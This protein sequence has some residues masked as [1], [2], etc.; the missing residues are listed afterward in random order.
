MSRL[1]DR[2]IKYVS[3]D[4]QSQEFTGTIPSTEKQLVLS[5][6]LKEE[7]EELGLSDV[8]MTEHGYVYATIP[9]NTDH[10]CPVVGFL[11]HMDTSPD[12]SGA[13]VKPQ[14]VYNYDG[15]IITLN[16]ELG[17]VT[18]PA[19]FPDLKKYIGKDLITSDG[20]TL[21]GGDDKAGIAEIMAMVDLLTK[22]NDIKHG[23]VKIAFTPDEEI[24]HGPDFFDIEGWGAD[25]AYTVDG[26]SF[27][28]IEY[29][30]FNA[31]DLYVTVHGRNIHPGDAKGRMKNSI[32]IAM[33]YE[34]LLPAAQK[35]EYTEKYEG[36]Y[37][38]NEI[39]GN[40]EN[41]K[42]HYLIRDHDREKFEEKKDLARK[43]GEFLNLKY[44]A[45]TVDVDITDTYYNMAE[46]I[47][48]NM[49][50]IDTACEVLKELGTTPVIEPIR[51][52]TD[53]CRLSFMGL[54]CPN[55]C[56]GFE[57]AHGRNEFV[58]IQD[59]HSCVRLLVGIVERFA[60]M[61]RDVL[62]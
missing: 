2:F 50:L 17:I 47:R 8:S 22:S 30:T 28:E 31:A 59:M 19:E 24:G 60:K 46:K 53:G 39:G 35:P 29:E 25:V 33:E 9:G 3:Y 62:Q 38:L 54:P 40:V 52:G 48:P 4:T 21:L 56:C 14:F 1:T 43:A 44:G 42:L 49:Y 20:T 5:K 34:S 61:K 18:D 27:G 12:C 23:T 7:L 45:G 16:E 57:N 26:G 37:H 10:D 15:G 13:N 55:L 51:G 32:L 58:C 6:V 41:T 11:S 36:F